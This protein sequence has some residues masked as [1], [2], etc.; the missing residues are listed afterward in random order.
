MKTLK[1]PFR[2]KPSRYYHKF[3]Y[4]DKF[5]P[6]LAKH[7]PQGT[8]VDVGA[9]IG[10]TA[11]RMRENCDNLIICIEPDPK[12]LKYLA[13]NVKGLNISVIPEY[14]GI[15]CKIDYKDMILIKSDTDGRD[16]EVIENSDLS[17]EPILFFE[18]CIN[19]NNIDDFHRM[20]ERISNHDLFIF[21][22]Y[23]DLM[24]ETVT[25]EELKQLNRW[26][27]SSERIYYTDVL[28]TPTK[29]YNTVRNAVDEWKDTFRPLSTRLDI[30]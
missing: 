8:V 9:N 21:D 1:K 20:Y 26:V 22:N 16:W 18:N 17:N 10:T 12:Y 6:I 23:G 19:R 25:I 24:L 13:Q 15:F 27:I 5:L 29:H 7:L 2:H 11:L 3:P 4:Y 30:I 14:A 28:A